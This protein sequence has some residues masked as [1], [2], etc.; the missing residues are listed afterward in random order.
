MGMN[1]TPAPDELQPESFAF[2]PENLKKAKEHITK[3]PQGKQQSAVMP[4]LRLAQQQHDGWVPRAAVEAIAD[5]LG[6][7]FIR[8]YEVVTFYTMYNLAPMGKHHIQCCTTTPCWLRGSDDVVKACQDEL[9]IGFG[10]TTED[11]QFTMTEVEC[12][13]ACVNAPMIE[14][15]TPEWDKYFEDL[16]Y[17]ST[18]KLLKR[19]RR[20][21]VPHEG[22]VAGRNASEPISGPTVLENQQAAWQ[23]VKQTG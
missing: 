17:D 12:L 5:M 14:V 18:R 23:K 13:G 9:G 16:D 22:S 7:P 19:L 11:G 10:Q 1:R 8:V 6:M 3:Y 15:T 20:G 21:E 2:T 4:L